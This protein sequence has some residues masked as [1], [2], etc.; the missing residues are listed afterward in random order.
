M[1]KAPYFACAMLT[2]AC[3]SAAHAAT[4]FDAPDVVVCDARKAGVI[5]SRTVAFVIG[6]RISIAG[7]AQSDRFVYGVTDPLFTTPDKW[8]L[9]IS[10]GSI[11]EAQLP[12]GYTTTNCAVGTPITSIKASGRAHN[13]PGLGGATVPGSA[14]APVP[15]FSGYEPI[16]QNSFPQTGSLSI[17]V[18]MISRDGSRFRV[19]NGDASRAPTCGNPSYI[20]AAGD[21]MVWRAISQNP[22]SNQL[23]IVVGMVSQNG[24]LFKVCVGDTASAPACGP[25][26]QL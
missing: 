17:L 10:G 7:N 9:V 24:D 11:T 2:I 6:S 1:I 26:F 14:P 5:S 15:P 8:A 22:I 18:G 3:S 13:L 4:L 20:S 16:G 19:C 21:G 25:A 23:R 12:A